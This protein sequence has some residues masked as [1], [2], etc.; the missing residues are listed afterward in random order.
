MNHANYIV[1]GYSLNITN[2]QVIHVGENINSSLSVGDSLNSSPLITSS[3][4]R[5]SPAVAMPVVGG[6]NATQLVHGVQLA[7]C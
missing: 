7:L 6:L 4:I 3:G 5:V 2:V 1:E